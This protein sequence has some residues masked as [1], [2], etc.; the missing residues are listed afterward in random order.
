MN[1][2]I[3]N[4]KLMRFNLQ[5]GTINLFNQYGFVEIKIKQ[6]REN[7]NFQLSIL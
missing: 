4:V 7:E 5:I 6:N 3:Y 2:D 1:F